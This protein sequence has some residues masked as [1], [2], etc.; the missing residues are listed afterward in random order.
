MIKDSNKFVINKDDISKF[1]DQSTPIEDEKKSKELNLDNNF[2]NKP[3]DDF[4]NNINNNSNIDKDIINNIQIS[5]IL[6]KV[7]TFNKGKRLDKFGNNITHGGKQKVTFIDKVSERSFKEYINVENFK[8][9]NKM[10]DIN[11][12]Q[13]NGCCLIE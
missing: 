1:K 3:D 6:N 9:Y 2:I 8:E 10:E 7:K 4:P 12:A 11:L 5:P 13:H